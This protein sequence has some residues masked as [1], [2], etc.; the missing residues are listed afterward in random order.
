MSCSCGTFWG[1]KAEWL[2]GWHA[3]SAPSNEVM[4]EHDS[5]QRV[6]VGARCYILTS[7]KPLWWGGKESPKCGSGVTGWGE[8]GNP[9]RCCAKDA[10]D[11]QL[12]GQL[13]LCGHWTVCMA[14]QGKSIGHVRSSG[15]GP[16][17]LSRGDAQDCS[18]L[19]CTG[20]SVCTQQCFVP[21]PLEH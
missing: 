8:N 18:R 6:L 2:V 13:T 12:M 19:N 1:L 11:S 10:L 5:L 16:C 17:T 21:C 20:S 3:S 4:C 9:G 14:H 15:L 7:V